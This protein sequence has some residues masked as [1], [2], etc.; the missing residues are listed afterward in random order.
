MAAYFTRVGVWKIVLGL[1]CA[2]VSCIVIDAVR[3]RRLHPTPVWSAA[4]VVAVNI[5]TYFAQMA[6]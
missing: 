4:L 2:T 6:E 5:L 3:H 1:M